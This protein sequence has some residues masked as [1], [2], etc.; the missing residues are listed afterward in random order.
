M[1]I[2]SATGLISWAP[3]T[4]GAFD[5]TVRA[6]NS[7]GTD[8]ETFTIEVV[9]APAITPIP[10][11][12]VVLGQPFSYDVEA[13]GHPAPTFSLT[14]K[15]AGMAINPTTGLI[16][17]TPAAAG[18]FNVTVEAINSQGVDPESFTIT[19][20]EEFL[21]FLPVAVGN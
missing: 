10:D 19:V 12:T 13:S 17:W 11:R 18:T 9:S 7:A 8:D 3:F 4:A 15:P 6:T 2:D 16:S 21:L 20:L 1:A 14:Q 5:V